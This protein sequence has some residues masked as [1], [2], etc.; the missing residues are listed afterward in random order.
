M[1]FWSFKKE[2]KLIKDMGWGKGSEGRV[3]R[4]EVVKERR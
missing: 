4:T 1:R 2:R 3:E